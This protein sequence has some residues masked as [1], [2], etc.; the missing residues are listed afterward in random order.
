MER[1]NSAKGKPTGR[2]ARR[3]ENEYS[4]CFCWGW[5]NAKADEN[6]YMTEVRW[7]TGLE[8]REDTDAVR[9]KLNE[10]KKIIIAS[11][12]LATL[13]SASQLLAAP[14]TVYSS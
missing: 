13:S 12:R 2:R 10:D 14:P 3:K 1:K 4:L 7:N 5:K 6:D 8:C 9:H 11:A